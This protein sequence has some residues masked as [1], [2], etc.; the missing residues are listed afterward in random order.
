MYNENQDHKKETFSFQ[1][2]FQ[3]IFHKRKKRL[4]T[5]IDR[6]FTN[7]MWMEIGLSCL[8]VIIGLLFLFHPEF[9]VTSIGVLFG[10]TILGFG[11]LNIYSYLKSSELYFFRFHVFY[12]ILDFILGILILISPFFFMQ[13]LTV[14]FGLWMLY[15]AIVKIDFAF[16][17][18]KIADESW[19][20]IFINALLSIFMGV[21]IIIN[22]F[23]NLVFVILVGVYAILVGVLNAANAVL[24]KNRSI[25]FLEKL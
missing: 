17:L 9:S 5:N 6:L 1:E 10:V 24:I 19:L 13:L 16:R 22:P 15:M 2:W 7:I 21:L 23:S 11:V 14:L 4:L 12:G 18:K 25:D 3:K 20:T 8:L